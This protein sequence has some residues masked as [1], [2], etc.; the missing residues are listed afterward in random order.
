MNYWQ[1]KKI[2]LRSIEPSDAEYFYDLKYLTVSL[3]L[4]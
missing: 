3:H 2:R 4:W 1:G